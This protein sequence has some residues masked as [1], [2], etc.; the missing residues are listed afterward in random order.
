MNDRQRKDP[1]WEE[2]SK[3]TEAELRA[4]LVAQ[5]VDPDAEIAAM[6]RLG[7]VMAAK[8][9]PQIER[10]RLLPPDLSKRFPMFAEAVA[11]GAAAWAESPA[12]S[13]ETSILDVLAGATKEDTILARV[14]GWSMRDAGIKDGDL[15]LVNVKQEAKDGDVVLAHLAGEGQ[16]VKRLRVVG[17]RVTLESANPDFAPILVEDSASLRIHGVVVGRAGK[18]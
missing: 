18:V 10:E 3:M 1:L 16:V 9:A 4:D 2:I 12:P 11:A 7:R 15:V 6:R 17:A 14:S 13:E 8:Y 5:G